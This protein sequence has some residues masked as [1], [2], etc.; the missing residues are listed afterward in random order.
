[1]L[2]R[3]LRGEDRKLEKREIGRGRNYVPSSHHLEANP[4]CTSGAAWSSCGCLPVALQSTDWCRRSSQQWHL[5]VIVQG[6][7][8]L[9]GH[10]LHR[11]DEWLSTR[12]RAGS[13]S[14]NYG[15]KSTVCIY[16]I[17]AGTNVLNVLP[18]T[19]LSMAVGALGL[20]LLL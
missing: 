10:S 16:R 8:G 1:M 15:S 12:K 3:S 19:E 4:S 7:R 14:P 18:R 20:L 6:L 13:S 11:C 17:V 2:L 5:D 9:P